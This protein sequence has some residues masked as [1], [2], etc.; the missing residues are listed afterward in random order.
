MQNPETQ[1][2]G[3]KEKAILCITPGL[4]TFTLNQ[5]FLFKSMFASN[6]FFRL[7]R[8]SILGVIFTYSSYILFS[9]YENS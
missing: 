1:R 8:V 7:S 5:I 9:K 2:C 4:I 3:N 6:E